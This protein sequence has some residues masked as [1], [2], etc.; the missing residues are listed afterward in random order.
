MEVLSRAVLLRLAVEALL[1]APLVLV[2][3]RAALLLLLGDL[4]VW[5]VVVG[6]VITRRGWTRVVG[7]VLALGARRLVPGSGY[8]DE[9]GEVGITRTYAALCGLGREL[10]ERRRPPTFTEHRRGEYAVRT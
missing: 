2:A 1:E 9:C 10:I 4:V 7:G 6:C 5:L 8:E 3:A